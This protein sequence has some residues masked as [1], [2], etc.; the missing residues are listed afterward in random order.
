MSPPLPLPPLLPLTVTPL[1]LTLTPPV[2]APNE[3]TRA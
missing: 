1:L 2:T 3:E